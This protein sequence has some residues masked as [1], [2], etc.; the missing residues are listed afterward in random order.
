MGLLK[1][2]ILGRSQNTIFTR[3]GVSSVPHLVS[4]HSKCKADTQTTPKSADRTLLLVKFDNPAIPDI[5]LRP[6][7]P[8]DEELKV[9]DRLFERS[10]S[11]LVLRDSRSGHQSYTTS[12]SVVGHLQPSSK[13][14]TRMIRGELSNAQTGA[15]KNAMRDTEDPGMHLDATSQSDYRAYM[16]G[17]NDEP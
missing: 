4:K 7:T 8:P 5:F 3:S 11:V 9:E 1:Q 10:G 16:A 17:L 2:F 13:W 6:A 15:S 12:S 14:K